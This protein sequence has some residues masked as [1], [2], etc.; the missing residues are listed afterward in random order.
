MV[1][2]S[3]MRF[4]MRRCLVIR[5]SKF[6]RWSVLVQLITMRPGRRVRIVYTPSTLLRTILR[7]FRLF[8]LRMLRSEPLATL[9][10]F[11][12]STRLMKWCV[13]LVLL[14]VPFARF[15]CIILIVICRSIV[16]LLLRCRVSPAFLTCPRRMLSVLTSI[17]SLS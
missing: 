5:P 6:K 16:L 17:T 4:A 12:M 3:M 10:R 2:L 13:L 14:L 1:I 8:P 7:W 11:P 15:R 9:L